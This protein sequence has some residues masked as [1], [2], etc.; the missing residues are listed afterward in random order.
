ML[1]NE[2][3]NCTRCPL[4]KSMPLGC[5]PVPGIGPNNARIMIIGEALGE[6]ESIIGKPFQGQ[7]GRLL[8]KMLEEAG[9]DREKTFVTNVV[10]CRPLKGKANRPPTKDEILVCA[11]WLDRE[12]YENVPEIIFTLGKVPTYELLDDRLKS[13]F[14][15]G[16][17]VGK[18][19]KLDIDW[20][21]DPAAISK[22]IVVPV[23]HP[24]YVM[25]HSR[26]DYDL[27]VDIFRKYNNA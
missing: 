21:G 18:E 8:N 26:K 23:F 3:Q 24:S 20:G 10:K 1:S 13:T 9:I 19:H 5:K 2:I 7:C 12:I 17:V 27:C 25:V 11:G 6:D 14:K 22:H 4:H 15:L 16:E